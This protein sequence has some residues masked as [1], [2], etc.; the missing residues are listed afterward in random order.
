V[1]PAPDWP[2]RVLPRPD[3]VA[4]VEPVT[5]KD[6][7]ATRHAYRRTSGYEMDSRTLLLRGGVLDGESWTGVVAVGKRVFCGGDK[8]WST[9]GIYLV[10]DQVETNDDGEE[11]SIAVPAFA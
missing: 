9:D 11:V 10:T 6:G 7:T 2:E 1:R 3:E 5:G 4:T 8:A